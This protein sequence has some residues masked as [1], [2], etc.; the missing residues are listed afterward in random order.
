MARSPDIIDGIWS[1]KVGD[2]Q[3]WQQNGWRS[4]FPQ[5]LMFGH[6]ELLYARYWTPN[7]DTVVIPIAE[8]RAA[9]STAPLR[10]TLGRRGPF[11]IHPMERA[12][13]FGGN[14]FELPGLRYF[15]R[16]QEPVPTSKPQRQL[17]RPS[18]SEWHAHTVE[19]VAANPTLVIM[20]LSG[21]AIVRTWRD[22][23]RAGDQV[24]LWLRLF[25]GKHPDVVFEQTDGTMTIVEV[26]PDATALEGFAQLWGDYLIAMR[27]ERHLRRV[28]SRLRG[29]LVTQ[30]AAA[31]LLS[32][33]G[34][35]LLSESGLKVLDLP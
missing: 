14:R 13:E 17:F 25:T 20:D 6:P 22:S 31:A 8:L 9:L 33:V 26:E 21:N 10:P 18:E 15:G 34:A 28:N 24:R 19:K 35:E 32:E 1:L 2:D 5:S 3:A 4:D 30:S 12:I 27:I 7:G 11:N 23:V 16:R 29:V